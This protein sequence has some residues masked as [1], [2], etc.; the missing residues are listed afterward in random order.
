MLDLLRHDLNLLHNEIH[1]LRY[2]GP[3][4]AKLQFDDI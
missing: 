1:L 2:E 4:G 3:V